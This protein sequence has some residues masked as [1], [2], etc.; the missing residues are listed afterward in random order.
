MKIYLFRNLI[1]HA[2]TPT[3]SIIVALVVLS[4][5]GVLQMLEQIVQ[6]DDKQVMRSPKMALFKA[7]S[8]V[9]WHSW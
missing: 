6:M 2:F 9:S 1:C 4:S 5:I 8:S 7:V 3:I